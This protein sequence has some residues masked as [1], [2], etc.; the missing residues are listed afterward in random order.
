MNHF[1]VLLQ[2]GQVE[3][4]RF[5]LPDILDL[6]DDLQQSWVCAHLCRAVQPDLHTSLDLLQQR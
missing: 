6:T 3:Y 5:S 2:G 1:A 4:L